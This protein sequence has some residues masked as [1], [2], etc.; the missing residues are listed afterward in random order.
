MLVLA[1]LLLAG[2][3]FDKSRPAMSWA[4]GGVI[5]VGLL[6]D[7]AAAVGVPDGCAIRR[8][9]EVNPTVRTV[10]MHERMRKTPPR[11]SAGHAKT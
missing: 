2:S 7:I 4:S 11:P 1:R 10:C 8:L 6:C 3:S 5:I 9:T